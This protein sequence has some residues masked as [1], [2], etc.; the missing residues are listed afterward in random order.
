MDSATSET[1]ATG[2]IRS[3]YSPDQ[4]VAVLAVERGG[5]GGVHQR[6]TP[7]E[8]AGSGRF[9]RWLRHLNARGY[10]IFIGMNPMAAGTR[11]RE[12]S[13]VDQVGRLQLDLDADGPQSLRKVLA[14]AAAGRLP[15]PAIV[16]RSSQ[17]HYQ[18]LWHTSPG[19][20]PDQ[21][22][23]T[24]ARLAERYGGD[25]VNDVTRCMRLPGFRNKKA[26]RDDAAVTWTD[27]GGGPVR[28][29]QF[30]HLPPAAQHARDPG[31]PAGGPPAR[32]KGPLSQSE[33]DWAAVCDRLRNGDDPDTVTAELEA[34]RPDKAKPRDYAERTVR[35]A[36]ARVQRGG[37]TR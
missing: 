19:W 5:G 24:M 27:Y 4:H 22:E 7:A 18:V 15:P 28:P 34:A 10:D 12:K 29:E 3:L 32:R 36:L 23:D 9:Q 8:A 20:K 11:G 33:R 30:S 13:D 26:G 1:T 14:D 21:A 25:N 17:D 16:V 35:K 2:F 37:R 31:L 6:I